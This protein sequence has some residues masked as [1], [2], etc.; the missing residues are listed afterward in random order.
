MAAMAASP[1]SVRISAVICACFAI[2]MSGT[3]CGIYWS[4]WTYAMKYNDQAKVQGYTGD[5]PAYDTCGTVGGGM[6]LEDMQGME[7]MDMLASAL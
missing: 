5:I 4:M 3:Y 7:G 2:A 1:K 6:L